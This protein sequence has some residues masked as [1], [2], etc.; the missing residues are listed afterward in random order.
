MTN[1]RIRKACK[2]N[3]WSKAAYYLFDA[4]CRT[5]KN[6]E[7]TKIKLNWTLDDYLESAMS[8]KRNFS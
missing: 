2:N 1:R 3:N 6:N 4:Y 5:V 7:Q 8:L